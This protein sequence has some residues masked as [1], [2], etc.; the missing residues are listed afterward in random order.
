FGG[1]IRFEQAVFHLRG[2]AAAGIRYLKTRNA[3]RSQIAGDHFDTAGGTVGYPLAGRDCVVQQVAEHSFHSFTVEF[4]ERESLIGDIDKVKVPVR[5]RKQD[6]R[7]LHKR[8]ETLRQVISG[9]Q[10]GKGRE[11]IDQLLNRLHLLGNTADAS[12]EDLRIISNLWGKAPVQTFGRELD[13]RERVLDLVGDPTRHLSPG[14]HALDSHDLGHIR[15]KADDAL[16]LAPL[17][18]ERGA[19]NQQGEDV[20]VTAELELALALTNPVLASRWVH[21]QQIAHHPSDLAELG[22]SEHLAVVARSRLGRADAEQALRGAI[23]GRQ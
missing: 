22:S 7:F 19:G 6:E 20:P 4:E 16:H 9:G 5:L 3:Q 15:K 17:I 2:N 21:R 13:R 23:D 12:I 8:I 10:A 1:E 14:L 18:G 11:L